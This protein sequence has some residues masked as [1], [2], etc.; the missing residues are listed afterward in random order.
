MLAF[1]SL[2]IDGLGYARMRLRD[3][4]DISP[5]SLTKHEERYKN[6]LTIDSP[7]EGGT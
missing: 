4:H 1:F 5:S 3:R 7:S 6:N 2:I